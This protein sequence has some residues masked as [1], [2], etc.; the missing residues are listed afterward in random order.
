MTGFAITFLAVAAY[1]AVHSL[2]LSEPARRA[3]RAAVGEAAYRGS[4]RLGYNALA[5]VLLVLLIAGIARLP[6]REILRLGGPVVWLLW[7]VRLAGLGFIGQCVRRV[8]WGRFLGWDH[9]RAW[10]RGEEPPG[11]GM[12]AGDLVVEGPYRYVR[13][14]MYAAGMVVVWA[15][16]VWTAN[17]LAFALAVSA[18]LWIGAWH[19]ERR[20]V[21]AFGEAYRRYRRETPAFLPRWPGGRRG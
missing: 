7:G 19:E 11:T 16:P 13:H 5:T 21:E 8:G 20:L 6:D 4:F 12:E 9:F 3:V 15:D 10:R 18:Y 14:P 1:G 17:R 2:L